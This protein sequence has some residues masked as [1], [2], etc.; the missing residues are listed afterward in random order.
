MSCSRKTIVL[1]KEEKKREM[2]NAI[3]QHGYIHL[4][5]NWDSI[6]NW[7]QIQQILKNS[8]KFLFKVV[9][10]RWVDRIAHYI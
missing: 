7:L 9:F 4:S 10:R 3:V 6:K 1:L 8:Y 5:K 2:N